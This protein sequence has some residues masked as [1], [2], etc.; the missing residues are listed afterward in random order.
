[1]PALTEVKPALPAHWYYDVAHYRRELDAIWYRD[2][3]CVGREES[4][5][6][7]GDYFVY[8]LGQQSVIV[9]RDEQNQLRAFY[10][11]CRHRGSIL[12]E[13]RAGQ[14]RKGRI[15][16]PYHSWT[17]STDGSLLATPG[18]IETD[19]FLVSDYSL[20]EVHLDSW[21]GFIHIN[22]S[23]EPAT[24]LPTQLGEEAGYV[25]NWPLESLRVVHRETQSVACNW[26]IFWENYSECYHCP[27]V[28]PELCKVMP[29]YRHAVVDEADLPDW[30]PDTAGDRGSAQIGEGMRT[31]TLDGQSSLPTLEGLSESDVAAGVVFASFTASMYIVA[32]PDYMRCVRIVPTGPESVELIAEWL[33]PENADVRDEELKAVLELPMKVIEQDG[34]VCELNQRGLRSRPHES[35]VLIAQEYELWNFHEWLR[36]RLGE[37]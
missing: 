30:E 17:Y 11:T 28:H 4:L 2:W 29:I 21:R 23:A 14:F 10:N 35:G 6:E 22:L 26:K 13:E 24:D 8:S 36:Q 34:E 1:M 16:C 3:I 27:R 18:R 5:A 31:W 19:D 7:P 12:C 15:V 32:H 9:T 33:L 20:Y 37:A 25:A